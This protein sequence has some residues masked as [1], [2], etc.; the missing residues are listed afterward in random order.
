MKGCIWF[1]IVMVVLGMVIQV[2]EAT[3]PGMIAIF[4][5]A[6]VLGIVALIKVLWNKIK[7]I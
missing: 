4:Y 2:F 6:C 1:F 5:V 7:G 3:F